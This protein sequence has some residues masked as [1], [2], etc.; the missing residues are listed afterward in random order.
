MLSLKTNNF[1]SFRKEIFQASLASSSSSSG[2]TSAP[3]TGPWP[4]HVSGPLHTSDQDQRERDY[5]TPP[6]SN[7]SHGQD[8]PDCNDQADRDR[9]QEKEREIQMLKRELERLRRKAFRIEESR[10][11]DYR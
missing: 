2:G 9:W 1:A 3:L 6:N 11:A 4:P 7:P 8:E 10:L 5:Y